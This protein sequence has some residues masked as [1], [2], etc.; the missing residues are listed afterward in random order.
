MKIVL[1]G[2]ILLLFFIKPCLSEEWIDKIYLKDGSDVVGAVV[3]IAPENYAVIS[4][5]NGGLDTIQMNRVLRISK[6]DKHKIN[7]YD[8]NY[9]ELGAYIGMPGILNPYFCYWFSPIGISVSGWA[10]PDSYA[11][12]TNLKVKLM[13]DY[14]GNTSIGLLFGIS[15]FSAPTPMGPTKAGTIYTGLSLDF[16]IRG[17]Q[18]S[19]GFLNN[20]GEAG[21]LLQLGYVYRFI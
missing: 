18:F 14:G 2:I 7:I 4:C 8:K 10:Y 12:Q 9:F 17:L 21:L 16:N 3:F 5:L 13:D 1:L 11:L 19:L 15:D 6:I 20:N